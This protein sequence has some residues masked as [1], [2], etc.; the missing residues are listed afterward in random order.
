MDAV[1]V[2]LRKQSAAES[3]QTPQKAETATGGAETIGGQDAAE[4]ERLIRQVGVRSST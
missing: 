1:A 4:L 3:A 2:G